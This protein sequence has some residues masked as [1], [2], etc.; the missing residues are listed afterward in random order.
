MKW[1]T[2][3]AVLFLAGC[4][5]GSTVAPPPPPSTVTSV[6]VS[7]ATANVIVGNTQ[8][9]SVTVTGT[10]N[11][12]TAV[13]WSV[14]GAAGTINTSGLFT[15]SSNPGP[16]TVAATSVESPSVM[17]SGQITVTAA[18]VATNGWYGTL[19]PSDG[20]TPLPLDFDLIQNG[21]TLTSG[22]VLILANGA[23]SGGCANFDLSLTPSNDPLKDLIYLYHDIISGSV[24]G[25]SI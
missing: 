24:N 21:G 14:S 7:P 2:L 6:T 4:G 16:V 19:V 3:V 17:G 22:P 12:S 25:Q 10:G 5:G 18:P 11:F 13:T 8:Q 15:A 23:L 1:L 20:S 9:F